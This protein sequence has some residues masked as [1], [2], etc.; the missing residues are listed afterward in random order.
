MIKLKYKKLNIKDID[1]ILD[2]LTQENLRCYDGQFAPTEKDWISELIINKN[3]ISI[4]LYHGDII[5]GVIISEKLVYDGCI[6]WYMAIKPEY[7]SMKLGTNFINF[8]ERYVKLKHKLNWVYLTSGDTS[9][10]F[11]KKKWIHNI[12]I[13]KSI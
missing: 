2:I 13:F 4:G 12:Q 8:F 1:I 9:L 10:N 5:I 11:Y 7:Q 3:C 6:I